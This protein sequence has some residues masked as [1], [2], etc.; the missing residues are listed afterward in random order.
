MSQREAAQRSR[1]TN[2]GPWR[3]RPAW[4]CVAYSCEAARPC[5]GTDSR[6]RPYAYQTLEHFLAL[7]LGFLYATFRLRCVY[8]EACCVLVSSFQAQDAM[9]G[10]G[11][12]TN[13]GFP[14]ESV[15]PPPNHTQ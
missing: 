5:R 6:H 13:A 1:Q 10:A 12:T 7:K 11:S 4:P 9:E 8:R 15:W 3:R 2:A 14:F